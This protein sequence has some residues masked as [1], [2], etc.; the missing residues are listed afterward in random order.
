MAL[1]MNSTPNMA[2][3]RKGRHILLG[4]AAAICLLC[5]S[6]AAFAGPPADD[7]PTLYKRAATLEAAGKYEQ[8]AGIYAKAAEAFGAEGK[9]TR[10]TDAL[11]KSALMYEKLAD[12][13]TGGTAPAAAPQGRPAQRPDA[14]QQTFV[15]QR[16][17]NVE[18]FYHSGGRW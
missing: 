11:Q 13:L 4:L 8:A 7:G 6:T 17:D 9:A 2:T 12:Q 5:V 10:Q 16:G 1:F 15:P 18:A 3:F 14:V